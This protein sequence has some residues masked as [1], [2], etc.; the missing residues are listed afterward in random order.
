[1]LHTMPSRQKREWIRHLITAKSAYTQDLKLMKTNQHSL[2]QYMTPVNAPHAA[3][4]AT[5][6]PGEKSNTPQ[7]QGQKNPNWWEHT[8]DNS[9]NSPQTTDNPHH[10][11]NARV[12]GT[13]T[14]WTRGMVRCVTAGRVLTHL[15]QQRRNPHAPNKPTK[16]PG[17]DLPHMRQRVPS[18]LALGTPQD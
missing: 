1:M 7:R 2:F 9:T 14:K 10:Q 17:T 15:P 5:H 4:L 8:A 6:L 16:H 13:A 18:R 3:N 11:D 12:D